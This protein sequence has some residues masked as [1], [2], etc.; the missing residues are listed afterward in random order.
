MKKPL[1]NTIKGKTVE[2]GFDPN[3]RVALD[4]YRDALEAK[5]AA[6]KAKAEAEVIL[7]DAIGDAEFATISGSKAFKMAQV[8]MDRP[9]LDK[10]KT[11]FPEVYALVS[12]DGS[13]E[14][15]K[16]VN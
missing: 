13:Y 5:K 6:D 7:R 11:E 14:F 2:V 1:T 3:I 8:I 16:T 12:V 4:K 15:I 10:L 9:D